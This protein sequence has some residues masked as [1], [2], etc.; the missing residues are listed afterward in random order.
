MKKLPLNKE[1][2]RKVIPEDLDIVR[3]GRPVDTV[4]G[5]MDHSEGDPGVGLKPG[6]PGTAI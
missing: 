3:G 2:L 4:A 6:D 5:C 1:V